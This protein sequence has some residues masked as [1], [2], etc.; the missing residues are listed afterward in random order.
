MRLPGGSVDGAV[1]R[2]GTSKARASNLRTTSL[3]DQGFHGVTSIDADPPSFLAL[4]W[5]PPHPVTAN[6][7]TANLDF[8]PLL[9]GLSWFLTHRSILPSGYPYCLVLGSHYPSPP[10]LWHCIS[11]HLVAPPAPWFHIPTYRQTAWGW[12]WPWTPGTDAG[13]EKQRGYWFHI[14]LV[15]N[16]VSKLKCG[17]QFLHPSMEPQ[18]LGLSPRFRLYACGRIAV[19]YH[20]RAAGCRRQQC[21]W[22]SALPLTS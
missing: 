21:I 20:D 12:G 10:P 8:T 7:V 4:L 22:I 16:H 9:Q 19:W 13:T 18:S 14:L 5:V 6:L 11:W 17:E 3:R 2:P 15:L 1:S